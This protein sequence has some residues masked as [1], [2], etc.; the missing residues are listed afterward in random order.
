M[1]IIVRQ[2]DGNGY[3]DVRRMALYDLRD[4]DRVDVIR[5]GRQPGQD[6]QV[7][8][9]I[10]SREH[11]LVLYDG[12]TFYHDYGTLLVEPT[13]GRPPGRS[14]SRNGSFLNGT[15]LIRNS[16][17]PWPQGDTIH[18]GT[19]RDGHFAAQLAYEYVLRPNE[20]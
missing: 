1:E 17:V 12:H 3:R 19:L 4:V 14:G 8:D 6:I 15:V 7:L 5:I 11:G 10:V 13:D 16:L 20:N 9:M 18:F 2:L